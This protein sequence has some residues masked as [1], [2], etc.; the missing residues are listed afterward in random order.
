M[1]P[2]GVEPAPFVPFFLRGR[3][4]SGHND[5]RKKK[6]KWE[7]V[8]NDEIFLSKRVPSKRPSGIESGLRLRKS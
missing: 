8:Y 6:Q 7:D 1:H 5:V 3:L 2:G 4:T